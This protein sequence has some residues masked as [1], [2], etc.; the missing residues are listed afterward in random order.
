MNS[1]LVKKFFEHMCDGN[2]D[3]ALSFLHEDHVSHDMGT[4]LVMKR[5]EETEQI[6]KTG[7]IHYPI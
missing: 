3:S 7:P 4:G 1:D 5:L 6:W 2:I